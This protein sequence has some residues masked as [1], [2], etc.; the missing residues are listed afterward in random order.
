MEPVLFRGIE[1]D[2]GFSEKVL[3][4]L[5]G[6]PVLNH[7]VHLLVVMWCAWGTDTSA[8]YDLYVNS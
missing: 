2:F 5:H 8:Y 1:T 3:V 6:L 7:R 4:V